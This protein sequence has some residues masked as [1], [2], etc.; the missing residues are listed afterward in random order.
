MC[1]FSFKDQSSFGANSKNNNKKNPCWCALICD[2]RTTEPAGGSYVMPPRICHKVTPFTSL[3]VNS[4]RR[5]FDLDFDQERKKFI[6]C[7]QSQMTVVGPLC[8]NSLRTYVRKV[9]LN[10]IDL[11]HWHWKSSVIGTK[12]HKLDLPMLTPSGYIAEKHSVWPLVYLDLCVLKSNH[13]KFVWRYMS[14]RFQPPDHNS[15]QVTEPSH[16]MWY[17]T[18][19][20][21][22]TVTRSFCHEGD[23]N[24]RLL[25]PGCAALI[26]VPVI[27]SSVSLT[28]QTSQTARCRVRHPC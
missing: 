27:V 4:F 17:A 10:I 18:G 22:T 6:K 13:L 16:G 7:G 25:M 20:A 26:K 24:H 8:V 2:T 5:V 9:I 15:A 23:Q 11:D 1:F 19:A 28:P 3:Y 14:R 12:W 21:A